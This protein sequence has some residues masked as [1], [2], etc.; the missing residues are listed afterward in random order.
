M[1]IKEQRKHAV[2]YHRRRETWPGGG[3]E[4]SKCLRGRNAKSE[5]SFFKFSAVH[6]TDTSGSYY[7]L[8]S[9]R[10]G[11]FSDNQFYIPFP[12]SGPEPITVCLRNAT[13]NNLLAESIQ[14]NHETGEVSV[15][16]PPQPPDIWKRYPEFRRQ[17]DSKKYQSHTKL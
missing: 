1:S 12:A 2:T 14:R 8:M 10:R 5:R 9:G 11:W 17:L 6:V 4:N 16:L 7:V 13:H 3:E 15:H